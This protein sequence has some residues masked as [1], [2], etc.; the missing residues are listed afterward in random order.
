MPWFQEAT[1][2][3]AVG[4][5]GRYVSAESLSPILTTEHREANSTSTDF[6]HTA[7]GGA[8]KVLVGN[9]PAPPCHQNVECR[10]PVQDP[11][12]ALDCVVGQSVGFL[13]KR[14]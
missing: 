14:I 9:A 4:A 10:G 11:Q 8:L 1:S 6:G 5:C 7:N 12:G 2:P 13:V 3:Q